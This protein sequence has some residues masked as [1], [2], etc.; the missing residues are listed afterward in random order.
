MPHIIVEYS[1]N[2][3]DEIGLDRL[4]ERVSDV[5]VDTGVFE[6]KGIRVRG[7]RRDHYRISDADPLNGFVHTVLRVGHGRAEDQLHAAGE[8][9]YAVICDH[10]QGLFDSRPLNISMEIQEIH[11]TLTFKKNNIAQHMA[12]RAS[13][14]AE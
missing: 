2:I 9:I 10:L 3:E 14:A 4:F 8:R 13:A 7:E 6:L 12:A 1:A 11:P 5:A